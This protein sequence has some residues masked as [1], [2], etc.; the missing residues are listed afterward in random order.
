M[1]NWMPRAILYLLVVSGFI[2]SLKYTIAHFKPERQ[3][4]L[5]NTTRP[6][7]HQFLVFDSPQA[8]IPTSRDLRPYLDYFHLVTEAMPD[9]NEG[10]LML[11]Y[12]HEISGDQKQ[13]EILL[14]QSYR[15]NPQFFFTGYNLALVSFNHGDYAQ[16]ADLLEKA[17]ANPPAVT[18]SRMMNSV[19][20]RQLFG[21]MNDSREIILNLRTAYKDAYML[22]IETL[23]HAGQQEQLLKVAASAAQAF[24]DEPIFLKVLQGANDIPPVHAHVM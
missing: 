9:N 3:I 4:I 19:I 8:S 13:A 5:L 11:G 22:L 23:S 20:Y 14:D 15:L 2:W 10:L 17:L 1:K 12:L 16:S 18:F 21:V 24:P 6:D 7:F